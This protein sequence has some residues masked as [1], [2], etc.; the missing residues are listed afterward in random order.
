MGI[1]NVWL[2]KNNLIAFISFLFF[3][4]IKKF[5]QNKNEM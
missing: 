2:E 1:Y 5:K 3:F 4:Q